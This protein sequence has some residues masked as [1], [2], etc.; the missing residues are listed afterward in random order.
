MDDTVNWML[1]QQRFARANAV[2]SLNDDPERAARAAELAEATGADPSVVYGD[3]D[4]WEAQHKAA[5]TNQIVDANPLLRDYANS[6]P[7]AAKISNDDWGKLDEVSHRTGAFLAANPQISAFM[8]SAKKF[9]EGAEAGFDLPGFKQEYS[10]LYNY[11]DNPLWKFFVA[12]SPLLVAPDLAGRAFS[13]GVTGI[14][15]ITGQALAD[16]TGNEAQG[17]RLARDVGQIVQVAMS[18]Q[19]GFHLAPELQGAAKLARRTDPYFSAGKEPPAGLDPV[20]DQV[21][22]QQ[23]ATDLAA[24]QELEKSAQESTTRERSPAAFAEFIRQHTNAK[25]GVSADMIRALYGEKVPAQGDGLLGWVPDLAQKLE[26]AE[27]TGGDVQI[28]LADWLAQAEPEV[29][30]ALQDGVRVRPE[31]LSQAEVAE[32]AEQQTARQQEA[33]RQQT[34]IAELEANVEAMQQSENALAKQIQDAITADDQETAKALLPLHD[35]VRA[36][37]IKTKT[38]AK[39][40]QEREGIEAYHGSPYEFEA[41]D[42]GKLGTGEGGQAFGHGLYF[43]EER[44]VAADYV[45]EFEG[46]AAEVIRREEGREPDPSEY[47]ASLYRVRIKA[48]QEQMLDWDRPLAEQPAIL[49]AYQRLPE[50]IRTAIEGRLEERGISSDPRGMR[51]GDLINALESYTDPQSAA[52]LLQ[53]VGIP[54]IRFLDQQSRQGVIGGRI[55]SAGL[56]GTIKTQEEYIEATKKL[57]EQAPYE[58]QKARFQAKIAEAQ[59][60][61]AE[62]QKQIE[63]ADKAA[64]G[65]TRNFVVFDDKLI[66]IL[67][68]N[69]EAVRGVREAAR[70]DSVVAAEPAPVE[71][72]APSAEPQPAQPFPTKPGWMSAEQYAT[73]LRL[74]EKRNIEDV[75]AAQKR[76]EREIARRQSK[77]WKENANEVR[78]QVAAD[79]DQRRDMAVDEMFR[80]GTIGGVKLGQMPKLGREFLTKEEI[81]DL[82]ERYT[83]EGGLAPDDVAKLFGYDTGKEMLAD[84]SALTQARENSGKNHLAWRR[85]VIEDEVAKRMEEKF[86]DMREQ[87]LAEAKEQALSETQIDLLHEDVLAM[88]LAA[89]AEFPI[90]KEQFAGWVKER[91]AGS[92]MGEVGSDR[93]LRDAGTAGRRVEAA[94]LKGDI[95]EAFRQRQRQY[96]AVSMAREAVALEREQARFEKLAKRFSKRE[97]P[98]V[99]PEYTNWIHDILMRVGKPVRRSIQDLAE[100][101]GFQQHATLADFVAYKEGHDMLEVP[102]ADFLLD[103]AFR[104]PVEELTTDEFRAMHD[105]LKALQKNG[106]MERK[107]LKEGEEADLDVVK[108]QMVE[109]L[110]TFAEK[111]YDAEGKRWLGPIPPGPAKAIRTYLAAHLQLESIFNRWDRGDPNGVFSQ[112]VMRNL[113]AAANEESALEGKFSKMLAAVADKADLKEQID[114]PLFIDPLSRSEGDPGYPM[115]LTRGHLRAIL[116]NAG[117]ES[118]LAKL[119]KGYGVKPEEVRAWLDQHATKEDWEWAQK[120]GDIFAEIK[121]A[122]DRMYVELSG[123]APESIDI[124]P[125]DTPH[126][127]MRGWYYPVIYHSVF[128]GLSKKLMGKDALEQ[129]N[130]VRA[131]TPRGYTKARTG[132][133]APM[134]LDLDMMPVRMRQM[135]HDIAMR[136]AVINASKIFY[137]R[138]IRVAITKHYGLEYRE[139]LVPYLRDVANSANYRSDAQAVGVRVSEFLRQNMIATLIGLNPGTVLKHG[140]TAAINS[141]TEVGGARFLKAVKGLF[142]I[143]EGTGETNW[144]FAMDTSEE[145]QRRHRHYNETLGGAQEK[146]LGTES[147]RETLIRLGSYPVAISDLLSAVPTWLAKYEEAMAEHGVHG[148][149]VYEADRAVRRAHGSTVITNRPAIAR[150]GALGSWLASLYGFFNHIM[151]RQFELAWKAKDTLG[152]VREGNLAGAKQHVPELTAGLFSYILLPA[153][154]EEMVTPLPDPHHESW[155]MKAAKGLAYTISAS[156]IGVRDLASAILRNS[157]P[158]VGLLSSGLKTVTDLVRD[159]KR[160][161]PMS[162]QHAGSLIQHFFTAFGAL[163]GLTNAQEGKTARYIYNYA[164]GQ[165]RPKSLLGLAAGLRFGTSKHHVK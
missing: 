50:N 78:K 83:R 161:L 143:N 25:I 138:D 121:A 137:D 130:Y 91:F 100:A 1:G 160:D 93:F 17:R 49:Q 158:A 113:A 101:I 51:G 9:W 56:K 29:Q 57:V 37:R 84:L 77:E 88:G 8:Y 153:L 106:R 68:R 52:R 2:L 118:N 4:N 82:P 147:L 61:I 79:L 24:L 63:E 125:L 115:R 75:A 134:A 136:P 22:A 159:V 54:G 80:T 11:V 65:G 156:W 86:G 112:Y 23:A 98:S 99:T 103:P 41:F 120:I 157:D 32:G 20:V 73:Y 149:A 104:K 34:Q 87:V 59:A 71:P 150:T 40:L 62:L 47:R 28:P 105:S 128:E 38:I 76:A 46:D 67:D 97:S 95:A 141:V 66:E 117:N 7:L 127:Q 58:E 45:K 6:T 144:R 133:S 12:T 135:I 129:E 90:T 107:I 131:T 155:G 39:R 108:T 69:G 114:N 85:S 162:K 109:Q 122:A 96:I 74:I 5:L 16:I 152:M 55:D 42:I 164:T 154:I 53:D 110:R 102:V 35:Q 89:G 14:S 31:G 43:A 146:L 111:H 119:A 26:V 123:V 163:T 116:L 142:S 33:Q 94:L 165:E 151:N 27:A 72:A 21:K 139:L 132:Y 60:K 70:L 64:A 48:R 13:A 44:K 81:A 148:D 15:A 19:G 10:R 18:G 92:K 30:K 126:G 3:L 140:P 145:L 36:E 124:K